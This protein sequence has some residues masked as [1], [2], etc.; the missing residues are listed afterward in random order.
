MG[1]IPAEHSDNLN[2]L[3]HFYHE[4]RRRRVF[5]V[6]AL[7]AVA[8]WAVIEIGD[9]AIS[10]G[11]V[12]GLTTRNLFTLALIGFPLVLIAGWFFDVTRNGVFRTAPATVGESYGASLQVKDYLLLT[13]MLAIWSG[14]YVYVH[15]PP[16]VE[17]SI[18]VMPFENRGN[19]PENAHFAFGIHDD[20]MTQLQRIGDLT[21]IAAPSVR[22]ID[23]DTPIQ[24][25]ALKLGVAYIMK[26]SVER[27]LDRIRVNV[28]LLDAAHEQQTWAGSYDRELS[29]IN[30]FDIRDEIT[31]AITG[32]LQA[33]LS[34][35]EQSRVFDL[36][37]TSLEANSHYAR[38]RQLLVNR[39]PEELVQAMQEFEAAVEIDP[40]FALAW[41]GIADAALLLFSAGAMSLTEYGETQ[42]RAVMKALSLN[43]RLGE[44]WVAYGDSLVRAGASNLEESHAALA[45]FEKAI[46][47]APN[48]ALAYHRYAMNLDGLEQTERRLALY[49]KA[50]QLDP[51]TPVYQNNLAAALRVLG[52]EAEAMQL[53][54]HLLESN[55]EFP[56]VYASIA[57]LHATG[58]GIAE[59]IQW[60]S[61][62]LQLAP[63]HAALLSDLA[64]YYVSLELWD[65]VAQVRQLMVERLDPGDYRLPI[66]D[67][68]ILMRQLDWQ[69]A[70]EA[71]EA[72]P[73]QYSEHPYVVALTGRVHFDMGNMQEAGNYWA[74][75]ENWAYGPKANEGNCRN[76]QVIM[77]TGDEVRGRELLKEALNYFE[78]IMPS[79]TRHTDLDER[80][81]ICY[82][83]D[84]QPDEALEFY[85]Q[86]IDHGHFDDWW[87]IRLNPL[88]EPFREGP[89]MVGLDQKVE[90]LI[91]EEREMVLEME[92]SEYA[93]L[94]AQ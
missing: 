76:M 84:N 82:L 17:K 66:L 8:A 68:D 55:P 57:G 88:L 61:E 30:L 59:A 38:G 2:K 43:D 80:R 18:A 45:A 93:I 41:T 47:L 50:I 79:V 37:T 25:A 70:L 48:Y 27:I 65:Q 24:Q 5:G 33:I 64:G 15:T 16:P 14:A 85:A 13:I 1:G 42:D 58:G 52:R 28:V 90:A 81:G 89:R 19:D 73:A 6:V 3:T 83:L 94:K 4:L 31:K 54:T 34:P 67:F 22:A 72:F 35:A 21:L 92:G 77:Q 63:A 51:M 56:F 40:D 32:E 26:G 53:Y 91:S 44:V 69:G 23:P 60:A 7:Y 9:M 78:F 29:A 12:S 49:R 74:R 86:R 11:L 10:S 71:L 20:L 39:Q 87:N 75:L 62:G 46:E 36:P